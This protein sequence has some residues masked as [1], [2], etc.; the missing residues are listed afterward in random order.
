MLGTEPALIADY[1]RTGKA[2]LEFWHI[3]DFGNASLQASAAAECAGEQ[4]AFWRMHDILFANQG[5]LRTGS[6]T[7]LAA[8]AET[9]GLDNA[10][11]RQCLATG[12][13]QERVREIDAAVKA[14]GVRFRPSFE[15]NGQF[16][17]GS[18]P[19]EQWRQI[20]DAL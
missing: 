5:H 10:A 20:L 4:G 7:T 2:R 3:T 13:A 11:F 18:P 8:L 19:L 17:Q 9:I 1:V 12:E 15:I 16:I 14:R 6:V